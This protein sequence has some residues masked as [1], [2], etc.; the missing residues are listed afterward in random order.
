[1][2]D[3]QLAHMRNARKLEQEKQRGAAVALPAATI[4]A[5]PRHLDRPKAVLWVIGAK[6]PTLLYVV[7][8]PGEARL[9]RFVV[10]LRDSETRLGVHHHN[11]VAT[12][13]FDF[14]EQLRDANRFR[15]IV[16]AV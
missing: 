4:A 7:E 6:Q 14:P 8:M 12:A 1:M 11:W 5:L 15:T 2:G 13:G 16:G 10:K 9:G 3:R